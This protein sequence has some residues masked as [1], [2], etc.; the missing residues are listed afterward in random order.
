MEAFA[1]FALTLR[2]PPNPIRS[3]DDSDDTEGAAGRALFLSATIFGGLFPNDA[4]GQ[5]CNTCHAMPITTSGQMA[6]AGL[7]GN[8]QEIK[9]PHLRNLYQK[10][11]MFGVAASSNPNALLNPSSGSSRSSDSRRR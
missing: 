9:I 7:T 1:D 4:L 3:L 5:N 11:G 2:Y 10:V 6:Q 8:Q